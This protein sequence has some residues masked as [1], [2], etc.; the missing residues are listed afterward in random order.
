VRDANL[1]LMAP[2]QTYTHV[3][4][5]RPCR[6]CASGSSASTVPDLVL[7]GRDTST[8]FAYSPRTAF[9]SSP[10]AI[11][12]GRGL[13]TDTCS[14][15]PEEA[16]RLISQLGQASIS[17]PHPAFFRGQPQASAVVGRICD[18]QRVIGALL[19]PL[20]HRPQLELP[21]LNLAGSG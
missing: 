14:I 3:H 12:E 18:G 19:A 21:G 1:A 11:V 10:L 13:R 20:A 5:R 2:R 16:P 9:T 17:L 15:L 4:L 6:G 7:S 8:A